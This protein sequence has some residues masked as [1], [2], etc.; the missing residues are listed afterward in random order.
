MSIHSPR[1]D[2]LPAETESVLAKLAFASL[3]VFAFVLIL[4]E[5]R[6]LSFYSDEWDFLLDRRGMSAHVLL[7]PHGP[8]LSLV[9]IL[10]YKVLLQVFGAS[11]YLPFRCLAGVDIVIVAWTI[12]FICRRLWGAWWGLVPVVLLV[13]LGPGY[14]TLMYP[15]QVGYT[16][17]LAGGL[18]TV[19]TIRWHTLRGDLVACLGLLLSVASSSQGVGFVIGTGFY[20]VIFDRSEIRARIRRSWVVIV[21]T[22]LYAAWY[23][24]YGRAA[25]QTDLSLWTSAFSYT[26]NGLAATISGLFALTGVQGYLL[27]ASPGWPILI[28]TSLVAILAGLR[29]WRPNAQ[30]WTLLLILV[31]LFFMTAVSNTPAFPRAYND[32]RYLSSN[33]AILMIVACAAIP[34]PHPRC[35]F[36]VLIVAL[37]GIIAVTNMKQYAVGRASLE[38]TA[39]YARAQTG[40]LLVMRGVVAPRFNPST[41]AGNPGRVQ[42]VEAG[43]F[44]S[45]YDAFG[46]FLSDSPSQLQRAPQP[47]R[48]VVDQ[49]LVRGEEL[50]LDKLVP[51]GGARTTAPVV[52]RGPYRTSGNCVTTASSTL[53]FRAS[54]GAYVLTASR[55]RALRTQ[56]AR[57]ASFNSLSLGSVS[58]GSSA[59]L[60]IPKD[61]ATSAPWRVSLVGLGGRVCRIQT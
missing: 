3:L 59:M 54:P 11:S 13:T 61:H 23:L 42:N 33:A 10:I 30:F 41:V 5:T 56:I 27:D 25:S 39:T 53:S 28:A 17:A 58:S 44:F 29:G 26:F 51:A 7:S 34:R 12:G 48:V 2:A 46:T 15:F 14:P 38:P 47:V 43:A 52:L 40:A 37:V 4:I 60:V 36:T 21:P 31:V 32:P 16:L 8:H 1:H 19:V 50:H 45:A 57:F 22:M 18:L 6:G 9:P 55:R 20:L 24:L 49:E 35:V